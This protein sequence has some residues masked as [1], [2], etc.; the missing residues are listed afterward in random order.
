MIL[1]VDTNSPDDVALIARSLNL[2]PI[3]VRHFWRGLPPPYGQG[4]EITDQMRFTDSGQPIFP[5][6]DRKEG[7]VSITTA[8]L[9]FLN[10]HF[11]ALWWLVFVISIRGIAIAESG[12]RAMKRMR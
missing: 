3:P 2:Q 10:A 5:G 12:A 8:I 9:A 6:E 7:G 1:T 4:I 11:W